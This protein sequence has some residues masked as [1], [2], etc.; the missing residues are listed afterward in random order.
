[1]VLQPHVNCWYIHL[2]QFL[3]FQWNYVH[4]QGHHSSIAKSWGDLLRCCSVLE[5]GFEGRREKT[6]NTIKWVKPCMAY[7]CVARA[8]FSAN[9]R[10]GR[11]TASVKVAKELLWCVSY[12]WSWLPATVVTP[13]SWSMLITETQQTWWDMP[14]GISVH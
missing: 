1:M 13:W 4:P 6:G 7:S 9:L 14:W 12:L 2:K 3:P 5:P 11:M 10:A 8:P